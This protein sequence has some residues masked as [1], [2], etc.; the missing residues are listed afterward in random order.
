MYLK[1]VSVVDSHAKM[2]YSA[3]HVSFSYKKRLIN[4]KLLLNFYITL[5]LMK[6]GIFSTI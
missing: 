2:K 5:W 6:K 4:E 1:E 3:R